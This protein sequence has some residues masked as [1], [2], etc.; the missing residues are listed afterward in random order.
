MWGSIDAF[1]EE[2]RIPKPIRTF[3]EASRKWLEKRRRVAFIVRMQNLDQIRD[4]LAKRSPLRFS[5]IASECS[6]KPPKT[7][8]LLN[9]LLAR[10]EIIREGAWSSAKYHLIRKQEIA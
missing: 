9:L 3:P 5:E 10:K 4:C 2:L 1:R 6:I 8:R 7:L